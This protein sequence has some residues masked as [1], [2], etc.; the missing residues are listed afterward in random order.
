[1]VGRNE[2]DWSI[3]FWLI[4]RE[5]TAPLYENEVKGTFFLLRLFSDPPIQQKIGEL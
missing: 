4:H 3:F 1:M 5:W 2:S